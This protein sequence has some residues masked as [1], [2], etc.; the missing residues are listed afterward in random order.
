MFFREWIETYSISV[1]SVRVLILV[2]IPLYLSQ[3]IYT[4]YALR[5]HTKRINGWKNRWDI[6]NVKDG[7]A[8]ENPCYIA[9]GNSKEWLW[10]EILVLYM[11]LV[12]LVVFMI[13]QKFKWNDKKEP[14]ANLIKDMGKQEG[15]EDNHSHEVTVD[16]DYNQIL[17]NEIKKQKVHNIKGLEIIDFSHSCDLDHLIKKMKDSLGLNTK[18]EEQQLEKKEEEIKEEV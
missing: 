7:E 11:N 18:P 16:T 12:Y 15:D 5:G 3:V 1:Y 13:Y 4:G 17:F 8:L 2:T 10:T 6:K 14:F 9:F